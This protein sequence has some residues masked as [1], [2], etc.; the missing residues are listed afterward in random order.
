MNRKA[1]LG[2]I[3]TLMCGGV[4][5]AFAHAHLAEAMPAAGSTV[6]AAPREVALRFTEP[7]EKAF[8]SIEVRDAAGNRV[9]AQKTKVERDTMRVPLKALSAGTYKVDWRVLS[10]DTHKSTGSFTFTVKP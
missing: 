1:L 6:G 2:L 5:P 4:T 3:V 10:V 8:S 7:L 9:E